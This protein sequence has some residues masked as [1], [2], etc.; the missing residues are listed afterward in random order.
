MN[1][2]IIDEMAQALGGAI[3]VWAQSEP[4]HIGCYGWGVVQCSNTL[5]RR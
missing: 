4:I 1:G 2:A 3:A 5:R